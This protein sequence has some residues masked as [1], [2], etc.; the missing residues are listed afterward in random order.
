MSCCGRLTSPQPLDAS[1][2]RAAELRLQALKQEEESR[3]TAIKKINLSLEQIDGSES[4]IDVR[5]RQAEL[6]YELGR[7]E[8]GLLGGI[9]FCLFWALFFP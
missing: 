1:E 8:L 3:K 9:L 7:E 6:E 4:N 2:R 5:I